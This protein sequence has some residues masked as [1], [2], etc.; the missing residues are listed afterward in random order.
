ML[1]SLG[2]G[3]RHETRHEKADSGDGRPQAKQNE[4][5]VSDRAAGEAV[6]ELHHAMRHCAILRG[7]GSRG[8]FGDVGS[9]W[10]LARPLVRVHDCQVV[11]VDR[12]RGS[13]LA[14]GMAC[15]RPDICSCEVCKEASRV[16][17]GSRCRAGRKIGCR[18]RPK[19]QMLWRK[20]LCATV[21]GSGRRL[22]GGQRA[23]RRG[24]SPAS[25]VCRRRS[26]GRAPW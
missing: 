10:T 23:N 20:T 15:L 19:A 2:R 16:Q 8:L 26:P 12:D 3:F 9:G 5:I 17:I 4:S 24:N 21:V 18:Q 6:A 13:R 11:R 7:G 25:V 1:D 14:A 22:G